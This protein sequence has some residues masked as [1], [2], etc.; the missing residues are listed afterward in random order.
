[1]SETNIIATYNIRN[2]KLLV[3]VFFYSPSS[4]QL[5]FI[6]KRTDVL[7][8]ET[9]VMYNKINKVIFQVFESGIAVL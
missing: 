3:N 9:T 6:M 5:H 2:I 1:M 4:Q 7:S 8:F